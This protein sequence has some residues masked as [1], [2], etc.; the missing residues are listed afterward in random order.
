MF[1]IRI[2]T[3]SKYIARVYFTNFEGLQYQHVPDTIAMKTSTG[4]YLTPIGSAFF[5]DANEDYVISIDSV[6]VLALGSSH[7]HVFESASGIIHDYF[8]SN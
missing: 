2:D 4:A 3:I 7:K 5:I 8:A 6:D 1:H